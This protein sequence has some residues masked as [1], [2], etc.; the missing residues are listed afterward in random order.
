[1]EEAA[2]KGGFEVKQVVVA[3]FNDGVS[4]EQIEQITKVF[5][6]LL[7]LIPSIKA[8][9]CFALFIADNLNYCALCYC[10]VVSEITS[11]E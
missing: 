4:E 1:M 8:F 7:N 3:K 5:A 6:N 11:A 10:N 2:S 9:R